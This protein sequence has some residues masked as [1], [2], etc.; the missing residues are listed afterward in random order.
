M[1]GLINFYEHIKNDKK[2]N[3]NFENHQI[4]L[5]FRGLINCASGGG[6]SNLFCNL[7]YEMNNTFHK[8]II[9]SKAEEPLYDM[10][11]DKLKNISIHYNGE[12]PE[13]Q[14]MDKSK[15][16]LIV[17]DDMVLSPN[18]KIGELFIRGRKLGFSCIYISQ[19][20]YSTP[21]IV[22]QNCSIVWLGKGMNKRDLRLILSEFA[23][24]LSINELEKL[25]NEL[26]KES[27]NFMMIN[28]ND[29][30]IRKN[31]KDIILKY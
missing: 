13:I 1:S 20:F 5:P 7:L 17:F 18:N 19:S 21:K 23:I 28:T 9:V 4:E 2:H 8:I 6:K 29:R 11:Q 24:G 25:Y 27:M 12:I 16:G 14:K 26:T 15:N 10:L 22:R 31:L 3:P 30:T